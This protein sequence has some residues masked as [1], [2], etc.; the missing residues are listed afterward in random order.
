MLLN[1]VNNVSYIYGRNLHYNLMFVIDEGLVQMGYFNRVQYAG[2]S[3]DPRILE[4]ESEGIY[5]FA[6]P[7]LIWQS[8]IDTL[9]GTAYR[10]S[11]LYV[12]GDF[13]VNNTNNYIVDYHN[14]YVYFNSSVWNNIVSTYGNNPTVSCSSYD[15]KQYYVVYENT[16]EIAASLNSLIERWTEEGSIDFKI[17]IPAII[18]GVRERT[19]QPYEIGG[20]K[21]TEMR[22]NLLVL[23]NSAEYRDRISDVIVS[24]KDMMFPSIVWSGLYNS[25]G[26]LMYNTIDEVYN[27]NDRWRKWWIEDV[28]ERVIDGKLY[29]SEFDLLINIIGIR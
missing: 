5:R 22:Y 7:R 25:S 17:P 20:T 15:V 6:Y 2:L 29:I 23:S 26:I 12:E 24:Q 16:K 1:T 8:S 14:G 19:V 9:Q 4:M 3:G 21:I 11:G 18:G 28:S 27:S 13:Y 10:F